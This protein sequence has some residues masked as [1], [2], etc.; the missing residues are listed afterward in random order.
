MR[1]IIVA[2]NWKMNKTVPESVEFVKE[3]QENLEF[4]LRLKVLVFP[5]FTSLYS[6]GEVINKDKMGFGAQNMYF[7]K[8]GAFTGEISADMIKSCGGEY[9][10]IGHSERRHIFGESDELIG[11]KVKSALEAGLKPVVCI[12]E[13]LD[14]REAG[15]TELVL[16]RQ[17]SAAFKDVQG[18]EIG[19]CVIAYEPVWAIGTGVNAT[20]EQ[21]SEAHKFVRE[22]LR[23]KYGSDVAKNFTILYGGS[24][25]PGNCRELFEKDGVDGFLV[26]GASLKIDSFL[27]IV[28]IVND[29]LE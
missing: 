1:Q 2:G 7:E 26:G 13:K 18:D 6:V 5:P 12:G 8:S 20:P 17:F 15:E 16:E 10:I 28:R 4:D 14:Q 24:V 22:L 3:L 29:M 25:K 9:V 23:K 21:A 11:R 19:S 27:E